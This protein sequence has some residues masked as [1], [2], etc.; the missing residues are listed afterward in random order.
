MTLDDYTASKFARNSDMKIEIDLNDI[1]G[2]DEEGRG[3]TMQESIQRQVIEAVTRDVKAALK[4]RIDEET[5]RA[6]NDALQAAVKDQMPALVDD[7]MNAEF[8]PVDRYGSRSA[9]TTFRAELIK[10]IHENMVYKKT[11]YNSDASAF[12]KAVDAV[13]S[14]NVNKFQ[15]EFNREVDAQFVAQAMAFATEKLR[16]RLNLPKAAR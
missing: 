10:A 7:L 9:A 1:F 8:Q 5:S 15:Q 6:I 4:K 11:Q 3:E 12:T 14:A 2:G 13:I 16:E